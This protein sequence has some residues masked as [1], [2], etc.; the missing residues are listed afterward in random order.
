[1]TDIDKPLSMILKD[2]S[3]KIVLEVACGCA[4]FSIHAAKTAK[5]VYCF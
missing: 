2:I 4:E 5:A 3:G 1:M